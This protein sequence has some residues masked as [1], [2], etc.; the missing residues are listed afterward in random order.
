[1]VFD[2]KPRGM[3]GFG[4][5]WWN[6]C[7]RR[8]GQSYQSIERNEVYCFDCRVIRALGLPKDVKPWT[9]PARCYTLYDHRCYRK[10]CYEPQVC[11]KGCKGSD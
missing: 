11:L 5:Y 8:C 1:M 3:T 4:P 6:E 10:K 7:C 2:I 9:M